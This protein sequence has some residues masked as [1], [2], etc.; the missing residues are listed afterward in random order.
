[1]KK[2]GL[3][4]L[5]LFIIGFGLQ[6]CEKQDDNSVPH[7]IAVHNFIWKGLN[8]YYLWQ[9]DVPNLSDYRFQNQDQL[10]NFLYGYSNAENLFQD[11]LYKP[12]SKFPK[13][14]AID[15]FSAIFPDYNI[16]EGILSGTTANNGVEYRLYYKSGS[17]SEVFGVVV[18]ILP[19]SDAATKNIHRGDIFYAVNGVALMQDRN[20]VSN[21][22]LKQLLTDQTSYTLNLADYNGGSITPNGASVSLTKSV[23]SENPVLVNKVITSGAHKIGYLMYNGFYSNYETELNNAFGYLKSQ[24]ITE[25]VLDLRYNGGGSI[26]TAT[27]LASMITGQFAGQLFAK[28]Q[29]NAKVQAY[30]NTKNPARLYNF[31]TNTINTGQGIN[32]LN[33]SKIF[34]LTSS[35]TASASELVINGLAPYIDVVQIGDYTVGKNVGSITMYDSPTFSKKDISKDHRYAMQPLVLKIVNKAGFGD[36]TLGLPPDV[37]LRENLGNLGILGDENEP[38]L[39]AAITRITTGGRFLNNQPRKF[40]AVKEI[41]FRQLKNEMYLEQI[42]EDLHLIQ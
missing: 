32:S 10:N 31:F 5:L 19:G 23:L 26:D 30:Y 12:I 18:Y 2:T 40:E 28:E 24:G 7:D 6:S 14:E 21:S 16:L 3:A 29:W 25:L 8:L 41:E 4:I 11:L 22:N 37:E 17:T 35:G 13:E 1:M 38:L 39:N 42:P 33:L 27:R 15:R 36:Y 9:A 34:I 20:N